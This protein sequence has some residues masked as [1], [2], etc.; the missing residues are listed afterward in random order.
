MRD[1]RAKQNAFDAVRRSIAATRRRSSGSSLIHALSLLVV[2]SLVVSRRGF[3]PGSVANHSGS[4]LAFGTTVETMRIDKFFCVAAV[5][6]ILA[7]AGAVFALFWGD[8]LDAIIVKVR[9]S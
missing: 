6:G 2:G 4:V 9:F 3:S 5:G 8:I 7:M 1:V